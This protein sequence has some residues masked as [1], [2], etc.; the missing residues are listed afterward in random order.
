MS[1]GLLQLAAY[2]AQDIYLSGNPQISFFIA[3]YR[4]YTNFSMELIRQNFYGNGD[5]GQKVYCV[6]EPIGDLINKTYLRVKLPSLKPYAYYDQTTGEQ[7]KFY[8]VNSIG[9]ALIDQIEVEIGDV[10]IDRQFGLWLEIWGELTVDV[11]RRQGYYDMIGKSES[12]VNL[13]N[14]KA[15]DLWIPLQFWFNR[16]LGSALPLIALQSSQVRINVTFRELSQLIISSNGLPFDPVQ[17]CT[18]IKNQNPNL[19]LGVPN[20]LTISE[21]YLEVNYIFLEDQERKKFAKNNHQYLI[22]QLQVYSTTLNT[23]GAT[24]SGIDSG[25]LSPELFHRIGLDFNHPIKELIWVIQNQ[26]VLSLYPYGGNEWFNFSTQSYRSKKKTEEEPMRSCKII[27]EGK[28]RIDYKTAK[29]F[30]TVVPYECHTNTPNN[31]IYCYSFSDKPEQFQPFGACNFSRIDDKELYINIS[32]NI[33]QPII[34]VY[35]VNYNILNIAGGMA[36]VEYMT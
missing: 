10:V 6:I 11:S 14:D 32:D 30:R 31:Y 9:N 24:P 19:G 29:Y 3:V 7:V 34:T 22:E 15:L 27:F 36:G 28:D 20:S 21:T 17:C 33:I 13:N 25:P 18:I 26:T 4:R 12:P 8:Y 23:R 35:G 2:G 1:G 16:F 5:F